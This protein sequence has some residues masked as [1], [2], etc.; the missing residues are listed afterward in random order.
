MLIKV[1]K[2]LA[3]FIFI[4]LF[5]TLL[6]G[7]TVH[8]EEQIIVYDKDNVVVRQDS[9]SIIRVCNSNTYN[10]TISI[11]DDY[12]SIAPTGN[13]NVQIGF[14]QNEFPVVLYVNDDIV[15]LDKMNFKNPLG[16]LK[17]F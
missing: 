13:K 15:Y 12:H 8:N 16:M 4:L 9:N 5:I 10:I 17:D 3:E 1:L 7:L 2:Y 14:I 11:G 6:V